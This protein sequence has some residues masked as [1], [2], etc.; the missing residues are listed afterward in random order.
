MAVLAAIALGLCAVGAWV[1]QAGDFHAFDAEIVVNRDLGRW[2]QGFDHLYTKP[3]M[4]AGPLLAGVGAAYLYRTPG[5]MET[6]GRAR[7][8][9]AVGLGVAGV[10]ALAS[11]HWPL[12]A[13]APRAVEVA[14]VASFRTV[15]GVSVAYGIL[16]SL[17]THPAGRFLGG[18]LS[19]RI[20]YPFSQLAYSAYLLNPIVTTYVDHALAPFVWVGHAEPVSLFLPFDVGFTFAAAA[21]MHVLVERPFM[22]LRPRGGDAQRAPPAGRTP[23]SS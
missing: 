23:R 6:L 19:S 12:V 20:L 11:T 14:F 1:V 16:L 7:V 13:T 5:V 4:R 15:F 10:A 21:G 22:E 18:L 3:W 8:G 17:S 9:S 2:A